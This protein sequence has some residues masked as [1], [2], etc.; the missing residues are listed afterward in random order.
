MDTTIDTLSIEIESNSSDSTKNIDN[1]ISRLESL[2]DTISQNLGNL[3][4]LAT[5]LNNISNIKINNI[6]MPNIQKVSNN[7]SS[8]VSSLTNNLTANTGAVFTTNSKPAVMKQDVISGPSGKG[9][10]QAGDDAKDA[11][12][13]ANDTNNKFKKLSNT[14]KGITAKNMGKVGALVSKIGSG[15]KKAGVLVKNAFSKMAS[16][17][18]KKFGLALLGDRSACTAVRSAMQEYMNYDTQL[19]DNLSMTWASLGSL[20]APVLEYIIKLFGTAVAYIN[21]FI[22][23]LTGIDLVSNANKKH[24]DALGDSAKKTLGSLAKFDDLN[25]VDFSKESGS[26]S[27]LPELSLP[28]IDTTAL[29]KFAELIRSGDWYELGFELGQKITNGLNSINFDGIIEKANYLGKSLAETLNGLTDGIDWT[30]LGVSLAQGLNTVIAFGNSFLETY[31]FSNFGSSL[32]QAFNSLIGGIDWQGLGNLF[33]NYIQSFIQ[34]AFSF[35]TKVDFTQLGIGLSTGINGMIEK[36]DLGMAGETLGETATGIAETLTT[37]LSNIDWEK[38]GTEISDF[39]TKFLDAIDKYMEKTDWPKLRETIANG[40]MTALSKIDWSKIIGFLIRQISFSMFS[41]F[42]LIAQAIS[43]LVTSIGEYFS[44]Y[45]EEADFG[46]DGYNIVAGILTGILDGMVNIGI[47][48]WDNIFIPF[49]DGFKSAFGIHSPSKVMEDMG[50]FIID[51]LFNGVKGVWNKVKSI[52]EDLKTKIKTKFTEMK[53]NVKQTFSKENISRIFNDVKTTI[54]NKFTEIKTNI[55]KKMSEAWTGVKNAFSTVGSFFSGVFEK[56]KNIFKKVGTT[57]GNAIGESFAN[58]VNSIIGFAENTINKFIKAINKAIGV[59]N[60]IPGVEIKKLTEIKIPKLA[61]GTN[62]IKAEGLYHL[63]KGEAVVPEKYNPAVNDQS[64]KTDNSD[65][66][67]AIYRL[68]RSIDNLDITNVVNLGNKTLY[69]ETVKYAKNQ[70]DI[71]GEN[72]MSV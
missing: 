10:K 14:L 35:I 71:Y 49:I 44:K 27:D 29:D 36:I 32:G 19:R 52:F 51:G 68:Q 53:D 37:T 38:F 21:A 9:L 58:V 39:C 11:G 2:N 66:V 59:I 70:N 43:G 45:I 64:V 67:S 30:V 48:I 61:T 57:V 17:S 26:G 6:K 41:G 47:W 65:V 25:T 56:I 72:V 18:V 54:T 3:D 55:V 5:A 50:V 16:N 15:A 62:E 23:A 40:I 4:K 1:L 42:G 7:T 69:K 60:E 63:H 28:E 46:D 22:K 20:L 24:M 33:G 13:K 12:K 31:D 8:M 34:T